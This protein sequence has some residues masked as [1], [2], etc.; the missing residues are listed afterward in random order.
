V[1]RLRVFGASGLIADVAHQRERIQGASH[2]IVSDNGAGGQA[3]VTADLV[4]ET[5]DRVIEAIKRRGLQP[6]EVTL[7]RLESIGPAVA[8]RPLSSVVWADLLSQAGANA[9]PLARC[10]VF[11]ATAG[12]IAASAVALY[13]PRHP[14]LGAD[15][16]QRGA[17]GART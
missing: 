1:L 9:R 2:G 13:G 4:D 3:L 14:R 7:L 10:S 5:P 11:M 12:V 16:D 6:E 17:A 8:Q 15:L